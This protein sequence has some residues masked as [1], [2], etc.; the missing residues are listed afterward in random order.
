[1]AHDASL[2]ELRY[3]SMLDVVMHHAGKQFAAKVF[4]TNSELLHINPNCV[5]IESPTFMTYVE[6]YHIPIRH[7]YKIVT[8]EAL[9]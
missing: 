8:S 3:L 1:M 6:G 5:P 7:A 4:Q 2:L 9:Q